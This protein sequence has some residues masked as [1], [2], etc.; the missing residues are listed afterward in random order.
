M[1]RSPGFT[2][3]FGWRW[4]PRWKTCVSGR[5]PGQLAEQADEVLHRLLG[6]LGGHALLV[7]LQLVGRG[8]VV[9]VEHAGV[10]VQAGVRA[11]QRLLLGG[12]LLLRRLPRGTQLGPQGLG[13]LL[14]LLLEGRGDVLLGLGV[15]FLLKLLRLGLDGR[16]FRPVGI[17]VERDQALGGPPPVLGVECR[18]E[19]GA[20]AIVVGLGDR[21]VAVIVALGATHRQPQQRRA[22]DLERVGDDLVRRQRLVR[23]R[24][25]R[26]RPP[27]SAGSRW[28]PAS[29]PARG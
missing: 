20:K 17:V 27:P 7:F 25:S 2:T 5:T 24:R 8:L 13:E 21:I 28:P 29:R 22:D 16:G 12:S 9:L 10:E 26:W 19:D 1:V 23:R 3:C 4:S 6:A 18:L 14:E 15:D 11:D